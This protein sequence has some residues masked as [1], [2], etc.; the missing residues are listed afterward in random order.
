MVE[1]LAVLKIT[2]VMAITMAI[3]S[4]EKI[5]TKLKFLCRQNELLNPELFRLLCN[6]L[7]RAYFDYACISW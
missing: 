3:K 5:N 7:I 4:L 1:C 6:S 2:L